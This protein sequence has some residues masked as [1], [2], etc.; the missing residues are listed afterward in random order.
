MSGHFTHVVR[1]GTEQ[2]PAYFPAWD[3]PDGTLIDLRLF[4]RLQ[5]RGDHVKPVQT[6]QPA[7][8]REIGV[9][10]FYVEAAAKSDPQGFVLI[11][12]EDTT[13]A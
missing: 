12:K 3:R 5:D 9:P 2:R 7:K 6:Y 8:L 13:D 10:E 1:F 11:Q 4:E